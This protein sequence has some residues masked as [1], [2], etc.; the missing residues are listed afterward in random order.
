[1]TSSFAAVTGRTFANF[2]RLLSSCLHWS[3]DSYIW[4]I[5]R[6]KYS[7]PNEASDSVCPLVSTFSVLLS[8]FVFRTCQSVRYWDRY[9]G[10]T[11]L[12]LWSRNCFN[13]RTNSV[14]S[15]SDCI[16]LESISKNDFI[17]GPMFWHICNC[18]CLSLFIS[19]FIFR[20]SGK[21]I[22]WDDLLTYLSFWL[23][24]D[25]VIPCNGT[26]VSFT[27]IQTFGIRLN[28][29]D[30][31]SLA[32]LYTYVSSSVAIKH[33]GSLSDTDFPLFLFIIHAIA[34]LISDLMTEVLSIIPYTAKKQTLTIRW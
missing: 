14:Q 8:L 22:N 17:N 11:D 7:N 21:R 25:Q 1:M 27:F 28:T 34:F 6:L 15:S 9:Q 31:F 33:L 29:F 12:D 18:F 13:H 16:K 26:T 20:C 23:Q 2:L 24:D 3:I 19:L 5:S 4:P 30:A 32:V 10:S